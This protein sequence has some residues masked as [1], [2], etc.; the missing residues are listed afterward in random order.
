MKKRLLSVFLVLCV[1]ISSII[2]ASAAR[3][4]RT[5][6]DTYKYL[7]RAPYIGACSFNDIAV[8]EL[9][10]YGFISEE[11][12]TDHKLSDNTIDRLN[13]IQL[14]YLIFGDKEKYARHPFEDV[15]IEYND[16]VMWAYSNNITTGIDKSHFG[17]GELTENA[18]VTFLLRIMGY[19]GQFNY[20]DAINFAQTVGF[21]AMPFTGDTFNFGKVALY[22]TTAFDLSKPNSEQTILEELNLEYTHD[23]VGYPSEM[24]IYPRSL[25]EYEEQ[26]SLA[27]NYLPYKIMVYGD[28]M[29]EDVYESI[30]KDLYED[31]Q[32]MTIGGFEEEP[33]WIKVSSL[34]SARS[35]FTANY[36]ADSDIALEYKEKAAELDSQYKN[37]EFPSM[38]EYLM[39]KNDL[40]C[41]Y[42]TLSGP[43]QISLA[44]DCSYELAFGDREFFVTYQNTEVRDWLEDLFDTTMSG[45]M[46]E[47]DVVKIKAAKKA[48]C[49]A[50]SYDWSAMRLGK[51]EAHNPAG[52]Y[53]NRQVVCDGYSRL[54]MYFM[55]RCDIPCFEVLGS[56]VSKKN[57]EDGIP[58]H[59][60]VKVKVGEKWYN[61]DICWADTDSYNAWDLRSDASYRNMA[62]WLSN[63]HTKL[64][65]TGVF[66]SKTDY[67]G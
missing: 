8:V 67:R 30:Y 10:M 21:D 61:M 51:Y 42:K 45:V 57:A 11:F 20:S 25:E 13:A 9:A 48:I 59:S 35:S 47:P 24:K 49:D 17:V 29:D 38:A 36:A 65:G 31:T 39:A 3:Q 23:P 22:T 52:G 5:F 46:D 33:W 43:I 55:C 7:D 64:Y 56:C 15:P 1:F 28:Y 16:A 53:L 63:I 2:P 50:V 4:N 18:Y 40:D 34:M 44:T 19:S 41:E 32:R 37:K 27:L 60:W 6:E 58:D 54:F 66:E 12:I 62:H 14:L 26:I